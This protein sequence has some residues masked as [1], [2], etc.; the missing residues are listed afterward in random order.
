MLQIQVQIKHI[1][2]LHAVVQISCNFHRYV[3]IIVRM[4]HRNF[5]KH[6]ESATYAHPSILSV[7]PLHSKLGDHYFCF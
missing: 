5:Y 1:M 4:L 6:A 3:N 7:D 2:D